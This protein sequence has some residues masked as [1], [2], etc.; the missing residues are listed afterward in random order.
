MNLDTLPE[1][2]TADR[3]RLLPHNGIVTPEDVDSLR[4]KGWEP[5]DIRLK[6]GAEAV[7]LMVEGLRIG[8]VEISKEQI[9]YLELE[10]RAYGF[11][12][13]AAAKQAEKPAA[14]AI[15]RRTLNEILDFGRAKSWGASIDQKNH[16][17]NMRRYKAKP[18]LPAPPTRGRPTK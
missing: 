18:K 5:V 3:P 11:Y 4:T 12:T 15:D 10:M 9:K 2:P 7:R 17:L 8:T 6:D 14:T 16:A 13:A 1:I